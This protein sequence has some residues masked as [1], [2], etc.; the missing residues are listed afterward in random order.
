MM[1][2]AES[3]DALKSMRITLPEKVFVEWV[4][5]FDEQKLIHVVNDDNNRLV[6]VPEGDWGPLTELEHFESEEPEFFEASDEPE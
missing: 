2:D 4:I 1:V 3:L 6:E 5:D